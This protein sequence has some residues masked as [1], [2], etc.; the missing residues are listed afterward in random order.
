MKKTDAGEVRLLGDNLPIPRNRNELAMPSALR[1]LAEL[2]A[3][4][5]VRQLRSQP[6]TPQG[7]QHHE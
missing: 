2:L 5:A 4:I 6:M 3:D 7:E 1:D